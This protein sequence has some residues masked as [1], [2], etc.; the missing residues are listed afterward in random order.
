MT[1]ER[2]LS[3]DILRCVGLFMIILAHVR[4]PGVIAQIRNFDVPLMVFVSGLSFALSSG[5][6]GYLE[7]IYARVK[8]LVFP[9]WIFVTIFYIVVFC[10][11]P[12]FFAKYNSIDSYLNTLAFKD[13]INGSSDSI[14]YTWIIRIFLLIAVIAPL[15]K[16]ITSSISQWGVLAFSVI[17]LLLNQ[18]LF[19]NNDHSGSGV[20]QDVFDNYLLPCLSYGAIFTLGVNHHKFNRLV[21]S[22]IVFFSFILFVFFLFHYKA[23]HGAIVS[24]QEYKYPPS[25]YYLSYALMMIFTLSLFVKKLAE[26]VGGRIKSFVVFVSSNSI[27]IYLWHIPVVEYFIIADVHYNFVVKYIMACFIA[28][29]I[30]SIQVQIISGLRI[31]LSPPMFKHVRDIFTG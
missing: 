23:V 25:G 10:F 24:T 12:V 16:S 17:L 18:Y 22:I 31:K 7:Y 21:K 26:K 11:F 3:I 2:D 20:L 1:K 14:G 28:T 27:W 5:G 8:R 19:S 15:L 13:S 4:P 6:R 29:V 30:M 9:V